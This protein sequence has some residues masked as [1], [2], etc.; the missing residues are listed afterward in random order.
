VQAGVGQLLVLALHCP[1]T[2]VAIGHAVV[3]SAHTWQGVPTAGQS[4]SAW[5]MGP[6]TWQALKTTLHWPAIH[7]SVGHAEVPLG[8]IWQ[9]MAS[10][11]QSASLLQPVPLLQSS[12]WQVQLACPAQS[13]TC[14]WVVEM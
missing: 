14:C 2:Q 12:G 6:A 5:H 4:L 9:A 13:A 7:W 8:Q 1:P 10:G 3:P 11:G